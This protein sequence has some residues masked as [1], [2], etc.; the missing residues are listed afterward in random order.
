MWI[1]IFSA[2]GTAISQTIKDGKLFINDS[3]DQY[4]KLSFVSQF[5]ARTGNYNPGTTI[6]GNAKKGGTD[7]GIR[8]F[9]LQLFGQLSEKVFFY[10]QFGINNFNSIG[11]RKPSFF[12]HDIYT[13]Y[14]MIKTKLS[15]GIGLSGWSGLA[16]F[17]S[18]STSTIMGLDAPL[19]QQATNDVTDQFLRKLGVFAKG[20]FDKLDY[21][22]SITQPFAFQKSPIYTSIVTKNSNFSSRPPHFQFNGYFQYQFLDQESNLTPYTTGTYHGKRSIFNIGGGI[23][24]Q[25]NAMNHL[26]PSLDTVYTNMLQ[27]GLDVF[28]DAPLTSNGASISWYSNITHLDFGP[29]YIRNLGVMNPANGSADL[30]VINGGGYAYPMYGTGNVF[31]TQI[32]YKFKDNLLGNSTLMPYASCQ[33]GNYK[34]L[35]ELMVHYSL[36]INYLLNYH[37]S[38][39]TLAYENRPVFYDTEKS[40][41]RKGNGI[42]QYQ[43]FF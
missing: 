28:W 30:T 6:F 2:T 29:G 18:P 4:L 43:I 32:G 22:V 42:L 31:Y 20:K 36:G 26:S 21:R 12:V 19:F 34:R 16:R 41:L 7:L 10:S 8:R 3:G 17:S 5:W 27:Y 40:I 9:R 35:P 23:V 24:F 39:L 11:E 25:K 1:L 37:K 14:E 38:K 33:I 13:E 15:V